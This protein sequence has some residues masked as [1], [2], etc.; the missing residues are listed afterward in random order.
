MLRA[1]VL[2]VAPSDAEMLATTVL[3]T[4]VVVTLNCT[5]V[6]FDG[7]VTVGGVVIEAL[8]LASETTSPPSGAAPFNFMV[9]VEVEPPT[10][11]VGLRLTEDRPAGL[12]VRVAERV[13]D[14]EMALIATV[15]WAATGKVDIE[16]LA[17]VAPA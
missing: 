16:K 3:A 15:F 5:D 4:P 8:S 6:A 12:M 1:A 13:L 14:P 9:P 2:V 7:T 11:F 17:R 10:T